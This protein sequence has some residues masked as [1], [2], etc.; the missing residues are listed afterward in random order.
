MGLSSPS[1]LDALAGLGT[2]HYVRSS[3]DYF[4][5]KFVGHPM[6]DDMEGIHLL[7]QQ[8]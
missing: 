5:A 3:M 4:A 8:E 6:P 1:Y 2:M 7:L